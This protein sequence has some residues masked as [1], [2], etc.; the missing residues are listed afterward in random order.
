[1]KTIEDIKAQINR[2]PVAIMLHGGSISQLEKD[3]G[4]YNLNDICWVSLGLFTVMEKYILSK[5]NRRLEIVFDCATVSKANMRHYENNVRLPRIAKYLTSN[6]RNTW[7]TTHGIQ[8]DVLMPHAS[9]ML[10][11]L[12]QQIM[13]VDSIFPKKDIGYWMGVPNSVTLLIGA[14]MAGGAKRIAIF[15]MDGY[16]GD[17]NEGLNSCYKPEEM[18][19][20]RLDALGHTHDA[21]INRDT[22]EFNEKFPKRYEEYVRMFGNVPIVNCSQGSVIKCLPIIYYRGV[23]RWLVQR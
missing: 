23:R 17:I 5:I 16:K 1:M 13:L 22:D 10:Y 11:K 8:R 9:L 19:Q 15:G 12:E 3:I 14:L 7:I 21:G 20:E 6:R 4:G 2:R 18:K